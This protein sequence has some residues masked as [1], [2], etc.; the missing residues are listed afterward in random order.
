MLMLQAEVKPLLDEITLKCQ[1]NVR[2]GINVPDGG[3]SKIKKC[4]CHNNHTVPIP[5][6]LKLVLWTNPTHYKMRNDFLRA[7][8]S[9][10]LH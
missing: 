5:V 6:Y 2:I 1:I 3:I 8:F 10:H 9:E 7:I 4:A